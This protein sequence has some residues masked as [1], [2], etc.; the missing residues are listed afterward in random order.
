MLNK[1]MHK[2]RLTKEESKTHKLCK[3]KQEG[4][5]RKSDRITWNHFPS[6]PWKNLSF[7]CT[8]E[9]AVRGRN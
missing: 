2:T 3:H 6:M 8:L 5:E 1:T 9:P 7:E 4:R